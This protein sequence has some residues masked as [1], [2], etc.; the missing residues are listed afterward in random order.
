MGLLVFKYGP[1]RQYPNN[2]PTTMAHAVSYD[3]IWPG[4]KSLDNGVSMFKPVSFEG[5]LHHSVYRANS[6]L[7][8]S[9]TGT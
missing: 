7:L 9:K 3:H 6:L 5:L 4:A 1:E 8:G 2:F